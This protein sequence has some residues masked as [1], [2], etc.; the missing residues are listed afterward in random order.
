[1]KKST[2]TLIELLV[3]IAIIAILAS[4]L[5]PALSKAR[6]RARNISCVNNLKQLGLMAALYANDYDDYFVTS[7]QSFCGDGA[8]SIYMVLYNNTDLFAPQKPKVGLC[9]CDPSSSEMKKDFYSYRTF[10][11]SWGAWADEDGIGYSPFANSIYTW[12]IPTLTWGTT[13]RVERLYKLASYPNYDKSVHFNLAIFADDPTL[14]SHY[15]DKFHI[16]AARADGSALTC[17]NL[18][19]NLPDPDTTSNWV[20]R[21][22][23]MV[24][25]PCLW[26]SFMAASD[27]RVN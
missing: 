10:H 20:L 24:T 23:Y 13:F 19:G 26:Q 6:S 17:R 25:S 11:C 18:R 8:V 2:F 27:P 21:L 5:L 16:N 15:S 3:V 14:P 22:S 7:E 4:M 12:N 9:P 1:M